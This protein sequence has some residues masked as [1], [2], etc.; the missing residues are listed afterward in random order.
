MNLQISKR[1]AKK[2]ENLYK[3]SPKLKD[4]PTYNIIRTR[5]QENA[6]EQFANFNEEHYNRL[7]DN[8][9]FIQKCS[10]LNVQEFCA[11]FNLGHNIISHK[12][13]P[14]CYNIR[15]HTFLKI[16]SAFLIYIPNLELFDIFVLDFS[17]EFLF[18]EDLKFLNRKLLGKCK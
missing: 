6:N 10:G 13:N 14:F 9:R 4:N 8:V 17:K 7:R 18:L 2:I 5:F 11:T 15:Q 3:R 1:R 12:P 16:Y